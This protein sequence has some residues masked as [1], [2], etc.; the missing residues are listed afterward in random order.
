MQ[1]ALLRVLAVGLVVGGIV[2]GGIVFGG[3]VRP[4]VAQEMKWWTVAEILEMK[5]VAERE[6]VEICGNDNGCRQ[7]LYFRRMEEPE[8]QV[9]E[10]MGQMRF[11][12]TEIDPAG[13]SVKV[14]F[15]SEDP[16]LRAMGVREWTALEYLLLV[17]LDEVT[18]EIGN[19]NH[20]LPAEPQLNEVMHLL[21]AG[22]VEGFV[23]D[24]E[25]EIELPGLGLNSTGL[26]GH[27][28]FGTNGFNMKGH[29]NYSSCLGPEQYLAG[30]K[31]QLRFSAEGGMRYFPVLPGEEAEAE[32]V[33]VEASVS[34][35][36]A[37]TRTSEPEI[38]VAGVDSEMVENTSGVVRS[39][40]VATT[41]GVIEEGSSEILLAETPKTPI[42]GEWDGLSC[43]PSKIVE[44]PWWLI[45]LMI[46]GDVLIL[47]WFWPK[48]SQ[49]EQKI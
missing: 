21:Y 16:M 15:M 44:F 6:E 41:A 33:E 42:T 4:V 47:W 35:G 26:I 20:L 38:A 22:E 5:K 34:L 24:A 31:C 23:T 18:P 7:E 30:A 2:F 1:K 10:M 28:V 29:Y 27:A 40:A 13:E 32:I 9:V 3:L 45:L 49:N 12:V 43:A 17:R 11:M 46:I 25:V 36:L 48:K 14:L 39:V 19:F 8:Y 37:V